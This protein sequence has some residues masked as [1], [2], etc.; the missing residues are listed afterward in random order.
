MVCTPKSSCTRGTPIIDA[1][2]ASRKPSDGFVLGR[3]ERS[4][5]RASGEH[6]EAQEART[7]QAHQSPRRSKY[8]ARHRLLT[9][10]AGGIERPGLLKGAAAAHS[11]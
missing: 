2:Q 4:A 7:S 1:L 6:Q 8:C 9:A 3:G 10:S 5:G 11:E